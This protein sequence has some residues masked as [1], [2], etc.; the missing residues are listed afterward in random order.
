[1]ARLPD[2]YELP[3][4]VA[5]MRFTQ[6][7][8]LALA[9]DGCIS[10]GE[11]DLA[12]AQLGSRIR[13]VLVNLV[14]ARSVGDDEIVER[15]AELADDYLHSYLIKAPPVQEAFNEELHQLVEEYRPA[16]AAVLNKDL[17]EFARHLTGRLRRIVEAAAK[18]DKM[19]NLR[20]LEYHHFCQQ[21]ILQC[22]DVSHPRR[23]YCDIAMIVEELQERVKPILADLLRETNPDRFASQ[24]DVE[25]FIME[26]GFFTPGPDNGDLR[27]MPEIYFYA[28]HIVPEEWRSVD[29]HNDSTLLDQ[30]DHAP[31]EKWQEREFEQEVSD[32]IKEV[33]LFFMR[34]PAGMLAEP[35]VAK[36]RAIASAI[37]DDIPLSLPLDVYGLPNEAG[38]RELANHVNQHY[39]NDEVF[40]DLIAVDDFYEVRNNLVNV[41]A[42][43]YY[44]PEKNLRRTERL[45]RI[46]EK[47][48]RPQGFGR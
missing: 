30:P 9:G 3:D 8:M 5:V 44:E 18:E 39:N 17:V 16:H 24:E 41:I 15:I 21:V 12:A 42:D 34:P 28:E 10:R 11:A 23:G 1:M 48:Q 45:E 32:K 38:M 46:K 47:F 27:L 31:P 26:R 7:V 19:R 22:A 40:Q 43:L 2:Q 20:S 33:L 36:L 13:R 4:V 25:L 29:N 35:V 37:A 6:N 14:R